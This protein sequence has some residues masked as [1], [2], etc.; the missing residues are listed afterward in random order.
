ML[1]H[2]LVF[3][4]G[5]LT[6]IGRRGDTKSKTRRVR[7]FSGI[8]RS[9]SLEKNPLTHLEGNRARYASLDTGTMQFENAAVS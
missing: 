6:P 2:D 4:R 7:G 1:R 9:G 8:L 3:L 5:R